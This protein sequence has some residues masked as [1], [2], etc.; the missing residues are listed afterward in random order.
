KV[1]ILD[2]WAT[3]CGPCRDTIP[4]I[5]QLYKKYHAEGLEVIG[6]SVDDTPEP[7]PAA[8]KELGMTYPVVQATDIPDIRSKFVF[9]SIPQLYIIDRQGRVAASV[10]GFGDDLESRVAPLLKE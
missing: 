5:E 3:W 2:F 9:N 10:T 6:I 4:E 7:V 8:V 1:V